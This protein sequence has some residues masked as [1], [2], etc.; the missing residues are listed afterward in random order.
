[1]IE[2]LS[3]L[4]FG[5]A[6]ELSPDE[7]L[8]KHVFIFADQIRVDVFTRPWG[9]TDFTACWS[10]RIEVDFESIRIPVVCLEDLITSKQ[11]GRPQDDADLD[12]L[13]RLR[14]EKSSD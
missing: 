7:I 13:R 5:I 14:D 3:E 10:R 1:M 8:E 12:G 4:G 2:A 11:T 9:L 6:R